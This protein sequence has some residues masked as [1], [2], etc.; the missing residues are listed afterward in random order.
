MK[1]NVYI[2]IVV[3]D[4]REITNYPGYYSFYYE[5]CSLCVLRINPLHVCVCV[6]QLTGCLCVCVFGL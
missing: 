6:L 3:V 5:Y 4:K 1:V 2:L